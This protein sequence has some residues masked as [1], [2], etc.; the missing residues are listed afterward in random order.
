MTDSLWKSTSELPS[1]DALEQDIKTDVLIVGGGLAGILCGYALKNRGIDCVI[2]EA[3]RVLSGMTGNT[4]AKIT[5][6]HGLIYS[7]L[8]DEFS[9]E[10]AKMYLKANESAIQQYKII[11]ENIDCNFEFKSSYVYSVTDKDKLD[12]ELSAL[13]KIGFDAK[14]TNDTPLPFEVAGAIEFENQA[15][16]NPVKFADAIINALKIYEHTMVKFFDGHTAVTDKG[17]ISAQKIII[18]THFPIINKHGFYFMKMYQDRSYVIALE[19]AMDVFGMYKDESKTGLSFRSYEDFLLLGGG[20]H[21]T[22]K[23]GGGFK[24][25]RYFAKK[26]YPNATEKFSWAAQDCMTLDGIPYIGQ[27][28]KS[29]PDFYVATGFNKWGMTSSMVAAEILSDAIEDKFNEFSEL[30]SPERTSLRPQLAVNICESVGHLIKFSKPR[31]SHLGC[32]LEWNSVERSWD[33]P[34]HGSRFEE[35]GKLINDPAQKDIKVK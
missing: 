2:V 10:Q 1:F 16:F 34:C 33:C 35:N 28:S 9:A 3:N 17:K 22:G 4:T 6:Q 29:L 18:A 21:R 27:Y 12:K 11:C 19:N 13:S 15:Q 23:Q 7:K 26:Y 14:F 30:F 32:A 25:I 20:S 31:C 24:E 8:I 5:S